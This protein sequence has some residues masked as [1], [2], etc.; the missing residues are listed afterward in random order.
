[1]PDRKLTHEPLCVRNKLTYPNADPVTG[2]RVKLIM[3]VYEGWLGDPNEG[4]VVG[5]TY[6]W[7][8]ADGI[9]TTRLLPYTAFEADLQAAVY[10]QVYEQGQFTGNARVPAPRW[11]GDTRWLRELLPDQPTAHQGSRWRPIAQLDDLSDVAHWPTPVEGDVL[12]FRD[13]MWQPGESLGT[14]ELAELVDVD[15]S[16]L[17]H[18]NDGD[19][20]VWLS[21]KEKWGVR[22]TPPAIDLNVSID[23]TSPLG[24]VAIVSGDANLPMRVVW[25]TG[26]EPEVITPDDMVSHVYATAGTKTISVY[27]DGDVHSLVEEEI[28]VSTGEMT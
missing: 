1:M 12:V 26:A 11:P 17:P 20:L 27:Y 21:D 24:V 13:G 23:P 3:V 6:A 4:R 8:D 25:E 5:T 2:E 22:Y 16:T 19:P 7:T 28:T 9:W 10:V 15:G 18:A 14:S